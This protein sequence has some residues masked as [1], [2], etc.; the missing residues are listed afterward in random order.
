MIPDGRHDPGPLPSYCCVAAVS[1]RE[2]Q[3]FRAMSNNRRLVS[4]SFHPPS[5]VL[6]S[7]PSR[8]CS[9]IG[10]RT[11][12][13]LGVDASRLRTP[14]PRHP[15]QD[16]QPNTFRVT[17]TGLSP[18]M[19]WR[20][21]Q[22]QLPRLGGGRV[23]QLHIPSDSRHQVR[24]ALCPLHSPLLRASQLLSFPPGTKMFPFP[25]FPFATANAAGCPA[26]GSPIRQSQVLRLLAPSLGFSQLA[27]AFLGA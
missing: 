13:E 24:F 9:A 12:L 3:P 16:T 18:S 14:F 7:F 25:G 17:L 4:G 22:L 19:A 20:S 10:L 21:S 1:F 8:Y 23:L 6:F 11:Y 2:N 15:T 27:T 26:T 5:G